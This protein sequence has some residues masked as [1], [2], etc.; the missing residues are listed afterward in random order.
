MNFFCNKRIEKN[1]IPSLKGNFYSFD[2]SVIQ[3][4]HRF[5]SSLR[6]NKILS[7]Q[8][9][10]CFNGRNQEL[11]DP[12]SRNNQFGNFGFFFRSA[13]ILNKMPTNGNYLGPK[14]VN[15]NFYFEKNLI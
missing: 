10:V 4:N 11:F 15:L 13:L 9:A 6:I 3:K 1:G 14:M 5:C 7:N 8:K 2:E 12:I